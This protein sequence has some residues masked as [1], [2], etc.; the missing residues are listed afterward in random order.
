MTVKQK[1]LVDLLMED[2]SGEKAEKQSPRALFLAKRDEIEEALR[3]GWKRTDIWRYL[4]KT[5]ACSASYDCFASYVREY[6]PDIKVDSTSPGSS[7][8]LESLSRQEK[9]VPSP[10]KPQTQ[11][12]RSSSAFLYDPEKR[13]DELY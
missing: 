10:A 6:L 13:A 8:L 5:G 12:N 2:T 4:K 7:S 3:A 11:A 1:R 9:S